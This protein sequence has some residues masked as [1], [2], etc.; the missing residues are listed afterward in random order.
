MKKNLLVIAFTLLLM[1]CTKDQ[2]VMVEIENTSALDRK[3]EIVEVEWEA[4]QSFLY[5][6][7]FVVKNE[8]GEEIPSQVVF[9]GNREPQALIFSADV[10]ANSKVNYS[11]QIGTPMDYER[12]TFGRIVPERKDDFAWENAR[13]AFRVYGPALA[14]ENPSNGIDIWLKKTSDMIVNKFYKEELEDGKSYHIDRGEGLDCYKVGHTLGAGGIAPF[15]DST[16]WVGNHYTTARVLDSGVLRTTFE[17]TY[18]SVK[19]NDQ[20]MFQKMIVSLDAGSQLNKASVIYNGDFDAMDLAAGIF[21]HAEL[22]NIQT[23]QEK[24]YVAYAENAVSDA[25]VPAGR[26]YVGV[27]FTTPVKGIF[28][29]NEHIA[30]LTSYTKG[31]PFDYYFGAGWSEWGFQSDEEWFKYIEE[32]AAKVSQPLNTKLVK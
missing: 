10:P 7:T 31:K 11:I 2:G 21:L 18:D 30:G 3:G 4:L 27:V 9:R 14:N 8:Q 22:G 15:A 28:Q 12:R 24:G 16:I 29:N 1:A 26:N 13:I 6:T 32:Y 19:V 23:N 20:V 5:A 25:G 17:L